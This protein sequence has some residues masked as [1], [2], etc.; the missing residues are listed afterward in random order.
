MNKIILAI[1]SLIFTT[2]LFAQTD[3]V[4]YK[5]PDYAGIKR[6]I[7]EPGFEFYY[8]ALMERM[9]Q[10]DSTL[11]IEEYR[12]LYYGFIFQSGFSRSLFPAYQKQERELVKYYQSRTIPRRRYDTVID[13]INQ[14]LD[15]DRFY[16]RG[17]N[18]LRY[19]TRLFRQDLGLASKQVNT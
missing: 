18:F 9:K 19:T 8:P 12:F 10:F 5:T 3:S 17:L 4:E 11:T 6:I 1:I 16:I 2:S 7:S 13:L 15:I 14:I